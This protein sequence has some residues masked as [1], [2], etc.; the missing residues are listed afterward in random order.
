MSVTYD[1]VIIGGGVSGMMAA[2]T[3]ADAGRKVAVISK[4][5]PA[6]CFSTGCIDLLAAG[7]DPLEGIASLTE[8]HPYHLV[9]GETIIRALDRF[10]AIM[11]AEGMTYVGD[12]HTNRRVLTSLGRCKI[13]CLV[14]RTM[15]FADVDSDARLHLLSFKRI[16]D[17]YPQYIT[18]RYPRARYSTYDAG[19]T[20][21]AGIAGRFE[22]SQ[23][24]EEFI[25]WLQRLDIQEE[26]IALPAVLGRQFAG[27]VYE[28]IAA[29][30]GRPLFEIPT[31]PPSIPGLRLFGG[32]KHALLQRNGDLYWGRGIYSVERIDHQIEAVTL[33]GTGRA[34]RVEGKSF[35]LATGS[36][37]SGGLHASMEK[38]TETV[39]NLPTYLPGTRKTWFHDDFF[40]PG[41]EIEK[42]GIRVDPSFRPLDTDIENLYVCGSIL[43]FSEVMKHRCGHGMAIATGVAA[44]Q[45]CGGLDS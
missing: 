18:A 29:A 35:I 19:V 26:R 17:F 44:A 32:L 31:L 40:A 2:I 28:K 41:H 5:D 14:P 12:Y 36:L 24:L 22:D 45:S 7:A 37:V 6:C 15:A 33:A 11:S 21:T 30:C 9:G 39:F 4:G 27:E 8:E 3:L 43:A 38:V 23:F 1:A 16:K 20:T 42:T 10:R 13:T 25:T 34:T